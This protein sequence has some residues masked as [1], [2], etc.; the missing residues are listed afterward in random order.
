MVVVV[1]FTVK[2]PVTVTDDAVKP[3]LNVGVAFTVNV[4][5]ELE[6]IVA[7]LNAFN[8]PLMVAPEPETI[9]PLTVTD[10]A[11][12]PLLNIGEAFTVNVLAELVPIVVLLNAFN[13]PLMVAPEPEIIVPLT[14]TD[15][16]VKP[17]L[18]TGE[19]FTVNVLA[20]LVP[21]IVLLRAVNKPLIVP[22]VP[23]NKDPLRV[24]CDTVK[25]LLNVGVAFTVNVL[26]E[27][28]P[29]TVLLNAFN[30]PL[31]VAPAP[32][33]IVPLTV[34]DDAVKPLLN[35][36]EAFTVNVLAELVPSTELLTAVNTPLIV[37]FN[38]T[39]TDPLTVTCEANT[40]EGAVNK[41]DNVVV[42]L[43]TK[44]VDVIPLLNVGVAF[45]VNVLAK[46]EPIVVLL[47]VENDP[48]IVVLEPTDTEPLTVS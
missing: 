33:T 26:S 31:I 9:V 15:D 22:L 37:S 45:T 23:T 38:P 4:L 17:L 48:L 20:E 16:A 14:V 27:V 47:K 41:P 35:T 5:A 29:S 6:P 3:L 7:L 19:A 30:A 46:L 18:N 28:V 12:K 34:T 36:G 39:N 10:D 24:I 44:F 8:E 32:E 25:P 1:P 21:S 43:T 13:A 11:V 2:L 42:P 40:P